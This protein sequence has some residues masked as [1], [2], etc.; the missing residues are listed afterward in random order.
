MC[1]RNRAMCLEK[2]GRHRA[3]LESGRL[4]SEEG[5]G[6]GP[7]GGCD[8]LDY[9]PKLAC[10]RTLLTRP[11]ANSCSPESFRV[12]DEYFSISTGDFFLHGGV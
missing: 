8:L 10:L 6:V 7:W 2:M 9:C 3:R 12:V 5:V 1:Q 11:L 4:I